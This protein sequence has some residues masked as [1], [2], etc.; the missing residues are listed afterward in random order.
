MRRSSGA[1]GL[2]WCVPG[3]IGRS[4]ARLRPLVPGDRHLGGAGRAAGRSAGGQAGGRCRAERGRARGVDPEAAG[5]QA[6]APGARHSLSREAWFARQSGVIPSGSSGS[7][8]RG[9]I[10]RSPLWRACAAPRRPAMRLGVTARSRR[11]PGRMTRCWPRSSRIKSVPISA[12]QTDAAPRVPGE[13]RAAGER[14]G[15]TRIARLRRAAGPVGARR[16]RGGPVTTRRDKQARP[17]PDPG[18]RR[19]RV[20]WSATSRPPARTAAGRRHHRGSGQGGL[21]LSGGLGEVWSGKVV[22]WALPTRCQPRRF[23][24]PATRG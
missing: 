4:G 7:G 2:S 15:R 13:L 19:G 18:L 12:H 1:G 24:M 22:G 6:A 9:P 23:W 10:F 5:E 11:A 17:A 14:H 20:R 3:V 8:A 21:P 16:R